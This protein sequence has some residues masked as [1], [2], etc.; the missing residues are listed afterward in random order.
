MF[1][2]F[3][4][5]KT[6]IHAPP[7]NACT[8]VKDY[9]WKQKRVIHPGLPH[10]H[11]HADTMLKYLVERNDYTGSIKQLVG[12]IEKGYSLYIIMRDPY[13]RFYS[14]LYQ[15]FIAHHPTG[16]KNLLNPRTPGQRRAGEFYNWY[17]QK[18]KK[19]ISEIT[20]KMLID[21]HCGDYNEITD[22]HFL[23]VLYHPLYELL[24][25]LENVKII[26]VDLNLNKNLNSIFYK[27]YKLEEM[28]TSE[29]KIK[30]TDSF[31]EAKFLNECTDDKRCIEESMYF[32]ERV[33]K[34]FSIDFEIYGDLS[35][36]YNDI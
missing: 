13:S 5:I 33:Q 15:K 30:Y 25:S 16:N 31:D 29:Y 27:P 11:P 22:L 24:P 12:K 23:P 10:D 21:Y 8:T 14:A 3:D 26:K 2:Y 4:N 18:Y 34:R 6:I 1:F 32:R 35:K 19:D 36:I 20:N 17:A 7:K 28:N 9:L